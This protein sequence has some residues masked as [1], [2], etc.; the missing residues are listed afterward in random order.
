MVPSTKTSFSI[1]T[2]R[3]EELSSNLEYTVFLEMVCGSAEALLEA[4]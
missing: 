2:M 4:V 3:A 1:R